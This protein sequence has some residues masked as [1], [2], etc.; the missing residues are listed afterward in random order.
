MSSETSQPTRTTRSSRQQPIVPTRAPSRASTPVSPDLQRRPLPSRTAPMPIIAPTDL[1]SRSPSPSTSI[2]MSDAKSVKLNT[3][4]LKFSGR[5]SDYQAWKD[6]VDLYMIGNPKEFPN[7]QIKVAFVL[8]WMSGNCHIQTWASNQQ[9]MFMWSGTWPTWVEFQAIMED[10][11]GDPAAEQ[12][13]QEYLLHYKQGKTPAHS[14]FTSLEL[15]FMLANINNI[16]ETFNIA[17]RAMNPRLRSALTIAGFPKTYKD[18]KDKLFLLEDEERKM[19]TMDARTLD[20]HLYQDSGVAAARQYKPAQ[21]ATI[22]VQ[23]QAPANVNTG[24][25]MSYMD[26]MKMPKGTRPKPNSPCWTCK[27]LNRGDSFHWRDECPYQHDG[28]ALRRPQFGQNQNQRQFPRP[29]QPNFQRAY[30]AVPNQ[31]QANP[32]QGPRRLPP[33]GPHPGG[34]RP[35]Q[36]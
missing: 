21:T 13:A 1:P 26:I 24:R 8:S 5:K 22:R 35:Q 20:S 30:A 7:D 25:R 10:Q 18:L 27:E 2:S 6:V 23:G 14:F 36:L 33:F 3:E 12:Q 19:G 4:N 11:F 9:T 29:P 17:K 31:A 15:W 32:P 34:P 16:V 28:G